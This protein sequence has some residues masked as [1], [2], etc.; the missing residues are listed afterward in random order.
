MFALNKQNI[1]SIKDTHQVVCQF[2]KWFYITTLV[3]NRDYFL[4]SILPLK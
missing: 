1:A 2:T 3:M 4:Q